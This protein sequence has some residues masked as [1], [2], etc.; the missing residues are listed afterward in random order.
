[1]KWIVFLIASILLLS[2]CSFGQPGQYATSTPGG[3][4][5]PTTPTSA[6]SLGL[7]APSARTSL[8]APSSQERSAGLIKADQQSAYAAAPPTA[9]ATATGPTYNQV[10]VP[11]GGFAPNSLYVSYAPQTVAA[12]NLY[13]NLVLWLQTSRSGNIW[14][15]EWYPNGMLDT[16]LCRIRLLPGLV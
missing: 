13:A 16:N 14:F 5:T 7:Q 4:P 8:S 2:S 1:M 10:I 12:C 3:A 15:Y 9:M 6:E 11:P